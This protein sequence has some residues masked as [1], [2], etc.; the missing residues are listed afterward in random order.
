MAL[1]VAIVALM[2][3][4]VAGLPVW[5]MIWADWKRWRAPTEPPPEIGG[6]SREPSLWW[7]A[8]V[9]PPHWAGWLSE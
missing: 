1:A 8:D 9:E 5:G 4:L 3:S 7:N 6:L 2:V